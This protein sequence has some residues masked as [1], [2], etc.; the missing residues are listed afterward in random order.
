MKKVLLLLLILPAFLRSQLPVQQEEPLVKWTIE[1]RRI[2]ECEYDLVFTAD[3]RKHW[4]IYSVKQKD[5]DGPNAASFTVQPG[6]GFEK[7]GEISE[8]KPIKEFDKV[9][10]MEVQYHE[11]Q[12]TFTQRI[13][14]TSG[15]QSTVTG[16]YEA[17][18][19]DSAS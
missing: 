19:C 8:S 5:P 6:T 15:Q 10:N 3:I 7:I 12:A 2:S 13:K 17:Q 18:V 16:K 14:L 4:H 9:F 11:H 1:S